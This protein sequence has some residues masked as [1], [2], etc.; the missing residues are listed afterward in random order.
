MT[1]DR[2]SRNETAPSPADPSIS[3]R[4]RMLFIDNLRIL[5]ITLVV[6]W[7]AAVTYGAAGT[8]PYQEGQADTLTTILFTLFYA[9][10]GPYVLGFFFLISGYFATGSLDRKG[11]GTFLWDWI[12]RLGIPLIIYILIFDPLIYYGLYVG[13]HGFKGSF[14]Q[15]LSQHF[16]GYR[17]LGVGP[18]WFIEGLLIVMLFYGLIRL[19]MRTRTPV[20]QP[21][22]EPPRNVSIVA[23]ALL[24]GLLTF[25]VR[26]WIPVDWLLIPFGLP[27]ALFPQFI[28]MFVIGITAYRRNWIIKMPDD[29]GR[30]WFRLALVFILVLFPVIFVVGGALE[31]DTTVFLGGFSWQSLAFS[32]WE[33]FVGVG[34][35]IWLLILFRKRYNYQSFVVKEMARGAFVVYFIHAPVLV[36]LSLALRGI[37]IYPL[38]KFA[39]VG[40]LAV[41]LCFGIAFVLRRTPL[42][43]NIL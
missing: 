29:L 17:T 31:G 2:D 1:D 27:L 20:D 42:I 4:E 28:A 32:V 24:L 30:F 14:W 19:I 22:G 25:L 11:V 35:I 26:I 34:M 43:R 7:H 5:L 10:N 8:W 40:P 15:Y 3:T 23:F 16:R 6:L 12:R 21:V 36:Y 13:L 37:E 38:L 18:M 9:A 39:L 33:Q 41:A